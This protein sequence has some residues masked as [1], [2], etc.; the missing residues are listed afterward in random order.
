MNR[1]SFIGMAGL[2]TA[3]FTSFAGEASMPKCPEPAEQEPARYGA[4]RCVS[5]WSYI[6]R[7]NYA[8]PFNNLDLDVIFTDPQGKEH[9]VPAF[10]AGD[11]VWK[12]RFAPPI[13]GRY[14]YRTVA[15]DA[16]NADLHGRQGTLEAAAYAG[17]HPIL[18]H[19]SI[20]VAAD[21]RHFEHEDGEHF[22]WLADTWW[23][24]LCYRLRWP[25][26]FGL[27]VEDR[28]AK[29]FTV[30]QIVAGLYPDMPPLD[31]RGANEAGFPWEKDYSRINPHY[32]DM[33]DLR[34]A[35]MV[36]RGL[37][38]CFFACW[39]YFLPIMG[40]PKMK[41]HW[42]YL[43]ARWGAL[44]VIWCLAGEATM[45]YY[46]S[47]D[48]K[49]FVAKHTSDASIRQK[50]GWT[51]VGKYL[52][53]LDPYHHP[54]TI[55]PPGQLAGGRGCVDDPAVLDFDMTQTGS[56]GSLTRALP[57]TVEAMTAAVRLDPPMPVI[58]GEV[59]YE[60]NMG[61]WNCP[62]TQRWAFWTCILNGAAGHTYG[63][64]GL[65]NANSYDHLY[66]LSPAGFRKDI[67]S[68]QEAYQLP[69]SKQ[70]GIGKAF[71][72]RFPWWRLEPHSEWVEPHWSKEDY[73]LP[74]AAGIPGEL[75]I[76]FLSQQVP[77]TNPLKVVAF[78]PGVNYRA[79]SFCARTGEEHQIGDVAPAAD[80]SW[81]IPISPTAEQWL[82]VLE[83]KA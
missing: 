18:K 61:G 74:Y 27:L 54:I 33:A 49:D 44:P 75:R 65:W 15:S 47:A 46:E 63:A 50:T 66:G 35:Y 60:G 71:L 14:T 19:G 39:G 56:S 29:G 40:I 64:G 32:F 48:F 83:K 76:I 81:T 9:R 43:V 11:Q 16:S 24:G 79:F 37:A 55:H 10:W 22:F 21:H 62:P 13:P 38:P 77:R 52:R 45:P 67:Q 57:L 4:Q 72:M 78:E 34:I 5:E 20:R 17:N 1:R 80:D 70:L 2:G 26:D 82:V 30:V 28:V 53:T 25:E 68:W 36:E 51:E 73:E 8:D 41:Q 6:S 7:K 42:R 59:V 31:P 69:G 12:I 3:G 58:D 23:M